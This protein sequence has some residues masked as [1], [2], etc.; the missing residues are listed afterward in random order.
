MDQK[1]N[2]VEPVNAAGLRRGFQG[3]SALLE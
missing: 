2:G 1:A 3:S